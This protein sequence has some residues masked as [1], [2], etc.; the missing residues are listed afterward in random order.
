MDGYGKTPQHPLPTEDD[1]I[2]RQSTQNSMML[3]PARAGYANKPGYLAPFG[4]PLVFGNIVHYS[5]ADVLLQNLDVFD[6]LSEA[7]I[8]QKISEVLSE[9]NIAT[10]EDIPDETVDA[11]V[12][13]TQQSLR[14]WDARLRPKQSELVLVEELLFMPL[15]VLP[16]GRAVWLRGQ[17]DAV[18]TESPIDWKTAGRGWD[19]SKADFAIQASLYIPLIAHTKG[20]TYDKY[21]FAIWDRRKSEWDVL[22]TQRNDNSVQAALKNA[23]KFAQMLAYDACPATPVEE[24]YFK[25]KRGWYCSA[26]YCPAWNICEFKYLD[27]QVDESEVAVQQL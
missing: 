23:W 13:E 25:Q 12:Q 20:I 18:T 27:D 16:D 10:I 5:I 24:N 3:C 1:I 15:G 21:R 19:A 8:L 26:R 14:Q 4:E 22:K 2:F 7:Y 9:E 17:P 11:W 6:V